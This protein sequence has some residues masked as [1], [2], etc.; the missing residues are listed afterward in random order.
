MSSGVSSRALYRMSFFRESSGVFPL[1]V[2]KGVF[3]EGHPPHLEYLSKILFNRRS[4]QKIIVSEL[5]LHLFKIIN[6]KIL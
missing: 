2:L 3:K 4:V 5:L 6:K 1:G